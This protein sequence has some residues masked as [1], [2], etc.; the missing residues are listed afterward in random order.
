MSKKIIV[1]LTVIMI[2]TATVL[3]GCAGGNSVGGKWYPIGPNA[4]T[5]AGSIELN[6]GGEFKTDGLVGEWTAEDG[7]IQI[8]IFGLH[9]VYEV[10]D[11]EG[12]QVLRR[13]GHETPEFCHSPEDAEEVYELLSSN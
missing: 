10:G 2:M 3:T 7:I 1:V 11:Y 4:A 12:Y 8:D 9:E 13:Q 6:S 5:A